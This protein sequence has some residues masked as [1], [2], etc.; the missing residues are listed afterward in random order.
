MDRLS[1]PIYFDRLC[2]LFF[3]ENR[4]AAFYR[5]NNRI[6]Y[7]PG[8]IFY[9]KSK[10]PEIYRITPQFLAEKHQIREAI[11]ALRFFAYNIYP[12]WLAEYTAF[13]IA[14]QRGAYSRFF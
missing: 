12:M 6:F 7:R 5:N 11:D 4:K 8:H 3:Y 13:R 10:K 1:Y 9:Q 14:V 2:F